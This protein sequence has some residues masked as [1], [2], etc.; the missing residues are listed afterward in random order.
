MVLVRRAVWAIPVVCLGASASGQIVTVFE[1]DFE[2]PNGIVLV[3]G[4]DVSIQPVTSLYGV[5][6][7]QTFSIETIAINGPDNVF[8]DPT[9]V[10]GEYALGLLASA[11]DDLFS[12]TFDTR[13]RRFVNT[14]FDLS[15]ID[16][17]GLGG[18]F[19]DD[20]ASI[21]E[22][23]VTVLDTPGGV[24]DIDDI[25]AY[26][27]LGSDMVSGEASPRF[28]FDWTRVV[29]SVTTDASTDGIVTVVFDLVD[30]GYAALDNISVR[31]NNVPGP[32]AWAG[33]V[34][35]ALVG[36]RRRR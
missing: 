17:A 12:I 7:Q 36:A 3:P 15:S 31:A 5:A 21:P 24:F 2:N 34:G 4:L 26:T 9:G 10:G 18:P 19:T 35:V 32:S 25:G 22:M 8:T 28:E 11:Q 1:E 23:R 14:F 27:E 29:V 30:G 6:F 33:L 13:G 20:N 16:L